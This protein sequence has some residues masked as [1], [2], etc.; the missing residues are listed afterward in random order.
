M[1]CQLSLQR[2]P[3]SH[4]RYQ[5]KSNVLSD[6]GVAER[7]IQVVI[8]KHCHRRWLHPNNSAPFIAIQ[9]APIAAK[10]VLKPRRW[11]NPEQ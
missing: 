10:D 9:R 7:V 3:R 1:L 4:D 11:Q 5:N 2:A 8:A 6:H